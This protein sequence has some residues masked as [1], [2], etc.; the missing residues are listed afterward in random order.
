M[1]P[2]ERI[3]DEYMNDKSDD[4]VSNT[5]YYPYSQYNFLKEQ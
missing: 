3:I 1:T 2:N 5:D 4:N